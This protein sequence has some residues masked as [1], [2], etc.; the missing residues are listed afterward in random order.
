MSQLQ[1]TEL[2]VGALLGDARWELVLRVAA[3]AQFRK[4][5]RLRDFLLYISERALSQRLEDIHEQQIGIR[6]FG[7]RSDYNP[8]VDNIVRVEAGELRRRLAQY[9]ASEGKDEP[10]VIQVPKGGYVPVFARRVDVSVAHTLDDSVATSASSG[11]AN[12]GAANEIAANEIDIVAAQDSLGDLAQ[13]TNPQIIRDSSLWPLPRSVLGGALILSLLL[14]GLGVL[15]LSLWSENRTL[16]RDLASRS[17][18]AETPKGIWPLLFDDTHQ[19]FIV[20]ADSCLAFFQDVHKTQI[21]LK[22]YISRKYQQTSNSPEIK[23][24]L[25]RQYTSIADVTIAGKI[26]QLNADFRERTSVRYARDLQLR[27]FKTNHIILFG[28]H[29][30]NPWGELVAQQRNFRFEFDKQTGQPF[31]VNLAR[32]A[33]EE[34]IYRTGGKDGTGD[35]T[36]SMITFLPNLSQTGNILI[37]EGGTGEGTEGAGEYLTNPE[38]LQKLEELLK[39]RKPGAWPYFE[40]LLKTSRIAGAPSRTVY[41]TH[42]IGSETKTH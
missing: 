39:V 24:L 5:T 3:S 40:L 19:T 10:L 30:S 31:C 33:G 36:Y 22:D 28:S 41:V 13:K 42:R 14:T 9:F 7:R 27:D 12:G 29:R 8:S 25:Q 17:G 4:S 35:E 1:N 11:A 34:L 26:L 32:R 16:Q 21:P 20:V 15:S 23:L 2:E 18:R 38:S 6:V 37:I